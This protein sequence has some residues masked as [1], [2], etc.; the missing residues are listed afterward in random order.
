MAES[1]SSA[2]L[3]G[4]GAATARRAHSRVRSAKISLP[5]HAAPHVGDQLEQLPDLFHGQGR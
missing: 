2:V 1:I 3:A 5:V 4:D